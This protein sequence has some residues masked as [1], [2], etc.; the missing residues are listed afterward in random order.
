MLCPRCGK[1]NRDIANYC[2]TCGL[3]FVQLYNPFLIFNEHAVS[4]QP[5][6]QK[7]KPIILI[8]TIIIILSVLIMIIL[9]IIEALFQVDLTA[10]S[11]SQSTEEFI[12]E[13]KQIPYNELMRNPNKY[14]NEKIMFNGQVIQVCD[15]SFQTGYLIELNSFLF[16]NDI[17]VLY[18]KNKDEP[19]IIEGDLVRIYGESKGLHTYKSISKM[20]ITVPLIRAKCINIY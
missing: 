7:K 3:S 13:C 17:Y 15:D 20:N 12:M 1:E 19:N 2:R 5:S 4:I 16:E 10:S 8:C 14:M 9:G 11:K 18:D 6:Y